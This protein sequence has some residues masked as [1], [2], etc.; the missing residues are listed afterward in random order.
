[1][2]SPGPRKI[3][4][5]SYTKWLKCNRPDI[6]RVSGNKCIQHIGELKCSNCFGNCNALALLQHKGAR[7]EL[8]PSSKVVRKVRVEGVPD[9]P[10]SSRRIPDG[11]R[12]QDPTQSK[13]QHLDT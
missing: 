9:G 10:A 1:M 2:A 13:A 6:S 11:S 7:H 3:N 12:V 5:R 4:G 8:V